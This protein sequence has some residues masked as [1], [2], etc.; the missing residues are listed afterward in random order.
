MKLSVIGGLLA[1]GSPAF[2]DGAFVEADVGLAVP[3]LDDDYEASVDESL[4]L[5]LR[6]GTTTK[7]GG[8]DIG[9]DFTP[10]NDNLTNAFLTDVDIQRF[11]FHVGA[12]AIYP[13]TPKARLFARFGAGI[14]LIHYSARGSVLGID[15]EASE[16][17]VGIALEASG[18]VMFD[19][20]KVQIGAKLGIPMAFHFE[21]DDPNDN[22]D[23]DLKYTSVD[24]DLSF[25]IA[26]P[27]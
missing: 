4:K 18:G 20:G 9:F 7:F 2:A 27:F 15:F 21:E 11:R 13:I 8:L 5:G 23:A 25:V 26:I 10:F 1:I 16:T 17:D 14:D 24:L 19:V 22:Q 3:L 6:L 12:R